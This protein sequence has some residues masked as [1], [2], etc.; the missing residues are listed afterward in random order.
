MKVLLIS[1]VLDSRQHQAQSR[2]ARDAQLVR[3]RQ[4]D[5]SCFE[6]DAYLLRDSVPPRFG[7]D[8]RS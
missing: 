7:R 6:G 5:S 1:R 8:S 2:F 3:A 4:H